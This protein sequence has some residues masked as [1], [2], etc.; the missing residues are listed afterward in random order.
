MLAAAALYSLYSLCPGFIQ[1]VDGAVVQGY[2]PSAMY[3][4]HWGIDLAAEPG[5]SVR[6]P[7]SGVVTFAGSVAGVRSVTIRTESG[8]R[9]S[10]SYLGAILVMPGATVQAGSVIGTS[11]FD[12]GVAAVH[13][14]VR[15]GDRYLDPLSLCRATTQGRLRLVP[16]LSSQNP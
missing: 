6:A 13:L 11:G 14:S 1:P 15:S 5:T 2:T 9:F 8:L 10:V 3:S 7:V 16:D 12:H 4:G